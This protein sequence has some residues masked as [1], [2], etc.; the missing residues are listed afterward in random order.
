[1]VLLNHIK[2]IHESVFKLPTYAKNKIK[3]KPKFAS[4]YPHAI[5]LESP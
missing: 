2:A 1:M 3:N 5:V 4:N